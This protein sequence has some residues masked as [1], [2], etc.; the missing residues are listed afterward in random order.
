MS[1]LLGLAVFLLVLWVILWLALKITGVFLHLLWII[2]I[3]L[4]VLWVIGKIRGNK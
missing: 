1:K 2:A 4:V 3:I